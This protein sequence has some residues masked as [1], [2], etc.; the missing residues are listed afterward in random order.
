MFN[1]EIIMVLHHILIFYRV[2][3]CE[4]DTRSYRVLEYLFNIPNIYMLSL[5]SVIKKILYQTPVITSNFHA[6]N[7]NLFNIYDIE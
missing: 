6:K 5:S 3:E 7:I 1:C 2:F 4:F